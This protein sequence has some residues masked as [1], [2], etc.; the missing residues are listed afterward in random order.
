MRDLWQ[1]VEVHSR[2]ELNRVFSAKL[3][4]PPAELQAL[5]GRPCSENADNPGRASGS[6][7]GDGGL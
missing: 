2:D 5:P 7:L 3:M 6:L 1:T 4:R